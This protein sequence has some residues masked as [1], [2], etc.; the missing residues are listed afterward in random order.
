MCEPTL[1]ATAVGT[2]ISAYGEKKAG[3][4]A[5][6]FGQYQQEIA[7]NNAKYARAMAQ[8][9]LDR[10]K[11][12]AS[13]KR[14]ETAQFRAKQL[15]AAAAS[16]SD[17]NLGSIVDLTSTTAKYGELDRLTILS[18]ARREAFQHNVNAQNIQTG[19]DIS[20]FEGRTQKSLST[21]KAVGTVLTG[22]GN[23]AAKWYDLNKAGIDVLPKFGSNKNYGPRPVI[24]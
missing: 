24:F 2:A 16:G 11:I 23:V 14:E 6:K 4:A 9:A 20:A 17:V 12:L 21:G 13:N 7:N 22:T 8:D 3:D 18:N 1:I 10:G 15:V 5:A 19:G